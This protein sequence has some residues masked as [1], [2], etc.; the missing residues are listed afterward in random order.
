MHYLFALLVVVALVVCAM[1]QYYS[2]GYNTY[3][4]SYGSYGSYAGAYPYAAYSG[5]AAYNP[6]YN[7]WWKK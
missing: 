1:G 6:G 5:A 7:Y 2:Y 3:P 4:H